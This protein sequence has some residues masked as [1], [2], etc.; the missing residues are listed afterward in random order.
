M[1]INSPN[2]HYTTNQQ[3][4]DVYPIRFLDFVLN[5]LEIRNLF[6]RFVQDPRARIGKYGLVSLLMHGLGNHLFRRSSKNRYRLDLHRKSASQAAA[7]FY[8][9][10]AQQSPC[11][12]TFDNLILNLNS[13]DFQSILPSLFKALCRQKV[14]LL[15][16]ELIPNGEYAISI[17]AQ[18]TH[19]YYE[20]SQH[21][22][23]SCPYCL[24]RTRGDKIWYLHFDLVAAF[25]APNGFKIPILF[26]RI[27][28]RPEWGDLG[29]G[30]WKQECERTAFPILI[31][32]LRTY[33][34][35][36]KF[37]IL[38]DALYA[39]D[40]ILSLLKELNLGFSIVKKAKVLKTVG[41]DCEGLKAFS[42]PLKLT[43]ENKR[44][45]IQQTIHIFNDVAYKGH[46]LNVIQLDEEAKKK[47]S[48]RFAKIESEKSHW[49]WI[50]HQ[51][52]NSNNM[53]A[54]ARQSRTRWLGE[55]LYNDLQCRGFAICHDFNR[56]PAAQTIR[57]YLILIAYAICAT[58]IYSVFGR[59]VLSQTYTII[60][61]MQQMLDDLTRIPWELLFKW[62]YP[63]QLRFGKDPPKK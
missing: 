46:K 58:L 23:Q 12:R 16:P 53:C 60:F 4:E 48:K 51:K 15:H 34:P 35:R 11:V 57:V 47:V 30:E 62:E 7:K 42:D 21:P 50:V 22:V 45:K 26:H 54:I 20:R 56:A 49:E 63:K 36:L 18:V 43:T 59:S 6:S 3:N 44:F 25:I 33:F 37:V 19:T 31:R 1:D 39:T 29:E 10:E 55:D 28:A 24:K 2:T 32:E 38:L 5:K 61:M 52:L 40:P 9:S 41:E 27:R 17:D 14:F 8:G 13:E